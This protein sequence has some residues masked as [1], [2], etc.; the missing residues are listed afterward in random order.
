MTNLK[1]SDLI[2][3]KETVLAEYERDARG[4]AKDEVQREYGADMDEN[5]CRAEKLIAHYALTEAKRHYTRELDN[6]GLPDSQ[7]SSICSN[8]RAIFETRCDGLGDMLI[9]QYRTHLTEIKKA[10]KKDLNQRK[11]KFYEEFMSELIRDILQP[12]ISNYLTIV[13][14]DE[15]K[16]SLLQKYDEKCKG[17]IADEVKEKAV[18]QIN[19]DI[20][21]AEQKRVQTILATSLI[22]LRIGSALVL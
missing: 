3:A 5:L 10:A 17:P 12:S 20:K 18:I 19:K 6:L 16:K 11:S 21:M 15:K 22:A 14:Y 4:P 9:H 2:R 1:I 7:V 8:K 13:S